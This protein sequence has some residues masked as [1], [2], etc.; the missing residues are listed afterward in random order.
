MTKT[1]VRRLQS[2]QELQTDEKEKRVQRVP[3]E[4]RGVRLVDRPVA[5]GARAT[6]AVALS[7]VALIDETFR[8]LM[9]PPG[10][11]EGWRRSDWPEFL[12]LA[13]ALRDLARVSS[14]V[15]WSEFDAVGVPMVVP[16]CRARLPVHGSLSVASAHGAVLAVLRDAAGRVEVA[17]HSAGCLRSGEPQSEA[18]ARLGGDGWNAL[19]IALA[20]LVAWAQ[21]AAPLQ[22]PS[23]PGIEQVLAAELRKLGET[24]DDQLADLILNQLPIEEVREMQRL[25]DEEDARRR[26]EAGGSTGARLRPQATAKRGPQL[27]PDEL[28]ASN[29]GAAEHVA[30]ESEGNATAAAA[31]HGA[32][33]W[34]IEARPIP[35]AAAATA[36]AG[37]SLEV[38]AARFR[39]DPRAMAMLK[40][41]KESKRRTS[42]LVEAA[43]GLDGTGEDAIKKVLKQ[44]EGCSAVRRCGTGKSK[45]GVYE[46]TEFGALLFDAIRQ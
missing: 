21:G 5:T 33:R 12:E 30:G 19:S 1:R 22:W 29:T 2:W 32:A 23:W 36:A 3:L 37:S 35:A 27:G 26:V 43:R 11:D 8:W 6:F 20:E 10:G 44:L 15:A 45:R 28:R 13:E 9:V 39:D 40:R 17:M 7:A 14:L 41:L 18:V 24:P 4:P 31:V 34:R 38:H 25:V 46:M 16:L 42:V